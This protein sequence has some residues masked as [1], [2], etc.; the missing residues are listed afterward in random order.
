MPLYALRQHGPFCS[1]THRSTVVTERAGATGDFVL[2][3]VAN[4]IAEKG[5]D[6]AIRALAELPEGV[7]LWVAG[8][9]RD[10]QSLERL[11]RDLS[12]RERVRFLGLQR[13]VSPFMQAADVFVCPSLWGEAAGLVNI[14]ALA[15]GLPSIASQVGG[16]PEIV[17]DG[18]TGCLFPPGDPHAL[19][20][21]VRSLRDDPRLLAAMS[22]RA[23]AVAVQL[24]SPQH[25]VPEYLGWY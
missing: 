6:V 17:A 1:R 20:E 23:R 7:I 9:G 16:I 13:D 12:L 3:V 21:R 2:L 19:A 25:L 22:D 11:A 4:L 8:G 10:Q 14:E 24:Y 15:C 5:V 18:E